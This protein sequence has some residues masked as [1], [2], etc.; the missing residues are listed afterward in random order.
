MTNTV[1]QFSFIYILLSIKQEY[2]VRH[3]SQF[4][5]RPSEFLSTAT[6]T[7]MSLKSSAK[8]E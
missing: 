1:F 4:T 5:G 6:V 8:L 3:F 2:D 7:C